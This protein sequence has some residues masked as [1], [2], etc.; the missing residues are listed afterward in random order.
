MGGWEEAGAGVLEGSNGPI[1]STKESSES[2]VLQDALV[3]PRPFHPGRVRN[4]PTGYTRREELYIPGVSNGFIFY[5][6]C[7]TL[8]VVAQIALWER[9]VKLGID[10]TGN[11]FKIG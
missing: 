1:F 5:A 11:C 3:P 6:K 7:N 10:S 2:A 4:T 8:A 9:T